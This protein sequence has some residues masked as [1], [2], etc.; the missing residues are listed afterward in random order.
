MYPMSHHI[1]ICHCRNFC[2]I[3]FL[4]R[5]KKKIY[6]YFILDLQLYLLYKRK[7]LAV[8]VGIVPRTQRINQKGLN[9]Y[10]LSIGGGGL[11][12][13]LRFRD[14]FCWEMHQQLAALLPVVTLHLAL[15]RSFPRPLL[16]RGH[17]MAMKARI[18]ESRVRALRF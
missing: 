5:E 1:K 10:Y 2:N 14:Y 6:E 8:P 16:R 9:I 11:H 3:R 15:R 13:H 12:N 18:P 7:E 4:N 17:A